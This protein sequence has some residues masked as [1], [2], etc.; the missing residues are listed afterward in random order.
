MEAQILTWKHDSD[1]Q[2]QFKLKQFKSSVACAVM[3]NASVHTIYTH[4]CVHHSK[5]HY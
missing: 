1:M 3:F 5:A 4:H 2:M